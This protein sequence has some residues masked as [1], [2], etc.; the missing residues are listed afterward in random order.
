MTVQCKL[1]STLLSVQKHKLA[2]SF[3]AL[4]VNKPVQVTY[5]F[6]WFT[7]PLRVHVQ[8]INVL[9]RIISETGCVKKKNRVCMSTGCA[10]YEHV[11]DYKKVF[12]Q[13][14]T[15][16]RFMKICSYMYDN[17]NVVIMIM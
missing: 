13:G 3:W 14:T 5:Q 9:G 10:Y 8:Y 12:S 16:K 15:Q 2:L 1:A 17:D 6:H 7:S 4:K 11:N